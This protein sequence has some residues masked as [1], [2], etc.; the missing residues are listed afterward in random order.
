MK[1]AITV[2]LFLLIIAGLVISVVNFTSKPV[3]AA[4][5]PWSYWYDKMAT[6]TCVEPIGDCYKV[7]PR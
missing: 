7:K 1:K 5:E 4:N 6:P 3:K 2:S